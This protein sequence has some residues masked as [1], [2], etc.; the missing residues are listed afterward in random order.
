MRIRIRLALAAL[1][2]TSPILTSAQT[3]PMDPNQVAR[4][5][6]EA[7]ATAIK[8]RQYDTAGLAILEVMRMKDVSARWKGRAFTLGCDLGLKTDDPE[9][10]KV[11]CERASNLTGANDDDRAWANATLKALRVS[12][13]ELFKK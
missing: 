8:A 12:H 3:A 7:A 1:F 11:M 4:I 13:P 5:K 10:V 9:M 2:L 6:M